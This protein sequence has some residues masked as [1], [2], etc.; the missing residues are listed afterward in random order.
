M[1]TEIILPDQSQRDIILNDLS[2]SI[3]VEAAA[4]TGKTTSMVGRMIRLI[5]TNK[6]SIKSMAAV[7]FTRKTASE[8]RSR[9][10]VGL[11]KE[12]KNSSFPLRKDL[13]KAVENIDSCF[14]G[15]IHSFCSRLLR[16]RPVEAK[17]NI[18]FREIEESE[19]S[20]LLD[21]AWER[22]VSKLY[23]YDHPILSELE[24]L[25][26]EIKDLHEGFKSR[27][28]HPDVDEWPCEETPAPDFELVQMPWST[29]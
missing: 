20:D 14:I 6:C 23:A 22:H 28:S 11:E 7:T 4:G 13:E 26:L 21:E 15:T 25:G 16:E 8:L 24:D 10:Q 29:S 1:K 2:S 19:D 18:D 9:F 27:V 17:V 12:L 5:A 3:L